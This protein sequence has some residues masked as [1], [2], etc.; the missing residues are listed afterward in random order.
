MSDN[1]DDFKPDDNHDYKRCC[2]CGEGVFLN[3]A[4]QERYNYYH[5]DCAGMWKCGECGVW[6]KV[7]QSCP[8]GGRQ[9]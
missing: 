1:P 9:C 2:S 8:C 5:P 6:N 4:F 3:E 7:E